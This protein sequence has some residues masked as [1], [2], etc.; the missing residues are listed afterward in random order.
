LECYGFWAGFDGEG[1]STAHIIPYPLWHTQLLNSIKSLPLQDAKVFMKPLISS[2]FRIY[3][4][5]LLD[6][7]YELELII[8]SDS[9]ADYHVHVFRLGE[10]LLAGVLEV[11]IIFIIRQTFHAIFWDSF[12]DILICIL[13]L[14]KCDTFW[15]WVLFLFLDLFMIMILA[16]NTL[17][18]IFE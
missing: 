17:I 11:F 9:L 14:M 8:V 4:I 12:I 15:I 3:L 10:F 1:H 5:K 18:D 13:T 7:L 6:Q 2:I 16:I